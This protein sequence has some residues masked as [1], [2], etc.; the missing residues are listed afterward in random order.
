MGHGQ[1]AD[2]QHA[3]PTVLGDVVRGAPV[4]VKVREY[5]RVEREAGRTGH[6]HERP[7][8]HP[9]GE[10]GGRQR[11]EQHR[12]REHQRQL[13]G[14]HGHVHL[15]ERDGRVR[16]ERGDAGHHPEHG[17]ALHDD[18][19]LETHP[20]GEQ[21]GERR[22][23]H[24]LA[25]ALH[26]RVHLVVHRAS[27]V[28][29]PEPDQRPFGVSQPVFHHVKVRRLGYGGEQ[30]AE[31]HR[32]GHSGVRQVRVI[33]VHSGRV[34]VQ[35]AHV[36]HYLE[37]G[38]QGAPDFGPGDLARVHRQHRVRAGRQQT[39]REPHGQQ[40]LKRVHVQQGHPSGQR[41]RPDDLQAGLA[42]PPVGQHPERQRSQ[43]QTPV[44]DRDEPR[45]LV[46]RHRYRAV[47]S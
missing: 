10:R 21:L 17:Q 9:V 20:V 34:H 31:H 32:T 47:W 14:V 6:D 5:G 45:R 15:G 2:G 30:G 36:H 23:T 33:Q 18:Q 28:V 4:H 16:Y 29:A 39:L 19:R 44:D 22:V 11:G 46:Y 43:D 3:Q 38:A 35:Y 8:S 12:A 25:Y 7:A 42:A 24:L 37:H 41:H 13:V 27:G 1:P 40:P 26:H